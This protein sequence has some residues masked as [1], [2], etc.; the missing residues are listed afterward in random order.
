MYLFVRFMVYEICKAE[1]G[2]CCGII[3]FSNHA[4][5][6]ALTK[7]TVQQTQGGHLAAE[8]ALLQQYTEV[9]AKRRMVLNGVVQV[10]HETRVS[11]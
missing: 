5:R 2:A 8:D 3:T 11:F 7:V 10:F 1:G 9:H 6:R 4:H